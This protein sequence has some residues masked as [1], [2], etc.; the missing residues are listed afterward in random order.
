M[1]N[2][3]AAVTHI[4]KKF[5]GVEQFAVCSI[6]P[7]KGTELKQKTTNDSINAVNSYLQAMCK[8]S[9]RLLYIDTYSVL[10][11]KG[12]LA[13]H[14]YSNTDP[15]GIH[16]NKAGKIEVLFKIVATLVKEEN[17]TVDGENRGKRRP[18]ES[19]IG[20]SD[21]L[22][23]KIIQRHEHIDRESDAFESSSD[24]DSQQLSVN[25]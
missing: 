8:R 4:E 20:S 12:Q 16:Y 1:F 14:L 23:K 7:Q 18:S 3:R 5:P 13:R 11:P 24:I 9:E 25:T 6:P 19:P 17:E 15:S 2:A 10:T 22:K 21:Q